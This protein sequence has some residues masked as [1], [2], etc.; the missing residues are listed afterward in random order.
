MHEKPKESDWRTF[1]RIVPVLRDRYLENVNCDLIKTLGARGKKPTE[2]FWD[3]EERMQDEVQILRACLDG[4]SRAKMVMFMHLMH[5][6]GM[7][8][9]DDLSSFSDELRER[10]GQ[11]RDL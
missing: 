3:T 8:T 2:Q 9:D 7:M 5:R 1:R 6:Y 10:I 4:H 11:L